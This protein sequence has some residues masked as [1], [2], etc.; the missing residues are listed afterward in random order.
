M[1]RVPPLRKGST[2]SRLDEIRER[3]GCTRLASLI[4][5]ERDRAWLLARVDELAKLLR[6]AF[7][8][9]TSTRYPQ[10]SKEVR[11]ALKRLEEK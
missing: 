5:D 2:M 3:V 7:E 11:A 9:A 10:W 1:S 4:D 6:E 8:P